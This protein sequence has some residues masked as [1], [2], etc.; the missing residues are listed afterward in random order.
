MKKNLLSVKNYFLMVKIEH[1]MEQIAGFPRNLAF[2]LK[3][4]QGSI[5]KQKIKVNSDLSTYNSGQIINFY[6]PVGRMID[7]RS[8]V[9]Y[10]TGDCSAGTSSG[11]HFPRFGLHS[12]IEQ[13]QVSINSK[14]VQST[15]LYNF[16]YN[17]IADLDSY[18]SFEQASKRITENYDPSSYFNSVYS[19]TN[20]SG[21]NND[22]TGITNTLNITR[23]GN[24]TNFY[25]CANNFLGF[26]N[27]SCSVLDTNNYGSIKISLTLAPSGVLWL[28]APTT[29]PSGVC[30]YSLKTVYLTIDTISFTN[31]LYYDMVK[32]KLET[33]GLNIAF[34]DYVAFQLNS[35]TRH[36]G[37]INV[38]T[39]INTSSLD[40]VIATFR[41]S[42]YST[43][44]KLVLSSQD[45]SA[46]SFNTVVC[47]PTGTNTKIGGA[48][49][50]SKYLQRDGAGFL[51]GSW[52]VNSQPFTQ[53]ANAIEVFNNTLQ[54]LN[55]ANLDTTG[56]LHPGCM[57]L[58][59]YCRH[60]F[61]DILS[62]E[63]ISG[64]NNW[65]VSGIN[66]SGSTI[67]I[68]YNCSFGATSTD[69]DLSTSVIPV[70]ICRVS[71]QLNCRMGRAIDLLE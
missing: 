50:N 70:I 10:A 45:A 2:S 48:F 31:S 61:A 51:N 40:Q 17:L 59:H 46:V 65:W 15:N 58:G 8:L 4:L 20:G 38:A 71:K 32:E 63:N 1:R 55:Y 19:T 30:D 16:I 27:G 41:P 47:N 57:S 24:D 62:L 64:D 14:P 66:G 68:Q 42:N 11:V 7:E 5:L 43:Q 39:Q 21:T 56:G 53:Q 52:F 54:A 25:M 13:F 3:R 29:A 6:L 67:T 36:N 23:Q 22:T 33:D 28:G 35:Q 60:Y 26:F 44:T 18:S 37:T 34:Y 12:L 69:T 9:I 49:N